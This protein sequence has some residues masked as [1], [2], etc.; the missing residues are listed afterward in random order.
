M[1]SHGERGIKLRQAADGD[2]FEAVRIRKIRRQA[3]RRFRVGHNQPDVAVKHF[4]RIVV[5]RN[6]DDLSREPR[7]IRARPMFALQ[8]TAILFVER[9]R[10][11]PPC[12]QND[13]VRRVS[14]RQCHIVFIDCLPIFFVFSVKQLRLLFQTTFADFQ[15]VGE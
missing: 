6:H 3:V 11:L 15:L 4:Q 10:V 5:A 8:I 12:R 9:L 7:R 2:F 14:E 1:H 13:H